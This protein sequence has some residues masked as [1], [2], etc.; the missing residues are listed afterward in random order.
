MSLRTRLADILCPEGG[1][2]KGQGLNT[3]NQ[4]EAKNKVPVISFVRI[5]PL[6]SC[7]Q[8]DNDAIKTTHFHLES[9]DFKNRSRVNKLGSIFFF[10]SLEVIV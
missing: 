10:H 7:G 2:N 4:E 9:R 6:R 1:D 5:S 8:T 3:S